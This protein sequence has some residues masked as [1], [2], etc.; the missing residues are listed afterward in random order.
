M[1][2]QTLHKSLLISIA[3]TALAAPGL[4]AG[5]YFE[6]NQT[7]DVEKGRDQTIVVEGWVEGKNA[8]VEFRESTSPAVSEGTYILTTDGAE[9][10]YLVNPEEQTYMEWDLAALVGSLG[11]MMQG[12]GGMMEME[13]RD[14]RV[15]KVAEEPGPEILGYSTTHYTFE[16]AYTLVIKVMGMGREMRTETVQEIW[17][18][19]ELSAPGFGLWLQ[20][21]PETGIEGLDEYLEQE[22]GKAATGF[23]LKT[24]TVTTTIGQKGRESVS[25]TTTE[26]TTLRE[27]SIPA[28][29]FQIPEGF[30]KTEMPDLGALGN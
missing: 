18:T 22:M 13:F 20:K 30:T 25:T 14:Q 2:F 8:R 10:V 4:L 7:T 28:S 21:A 27:E 6:S 17:S 16:S 23:P 15:E 29:R 3:A 11:Q 1:R 26:V 24:E 12:M 5:T 9:T 19:S